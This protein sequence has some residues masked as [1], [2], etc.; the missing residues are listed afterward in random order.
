[1]TEVSTQVFFDTIEAQGRSLL[2]FLHVGS[3]SNRYPSGHLCLLLTSSPQTRISPHL[4]L[5][6]MYL[7]S[8][9]RF[10]LYMTH[11][12]SKKMALLSLNPRRVQRMQN[13]GGSW[14]QL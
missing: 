6:A 2:R 5:S 13:S 4:Y 9:A 3:S 11:L 12:F 7:K 8:S 10:Y 1:M 14:M